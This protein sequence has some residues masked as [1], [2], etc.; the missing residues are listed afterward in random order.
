M[1]ASCTANA[2]RSSEAIP[3]AIHTSLPFPDSSVTSSPFLLSSS[4]TASTWGL[5]HQT[6]SH[7]TLNDLLN[8]LASS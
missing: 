2:N 3:I 1:S 8:F 7:G 5:L 4:N 6:T